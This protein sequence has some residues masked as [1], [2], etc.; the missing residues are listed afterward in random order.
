M[1]ELV[2][3]LLESFRK[4]F[5]APWAETAATVVSLY[6]GT[7]LASYE[8]V[9]W[10]YGLTLTPDQFAGSYLFKVAT[11]AFIGAALVFA[12]LQPRRG[13]EEPGRVLAAF[14]GVWVWMRGVGLRRAAAILLILAVCMGLVFR[15]LPGHARPLRVAFLGAPDFDIDAFAY[16]VYEF[17]RLQDDWHLDVDFRLLDQDVLTSAERDACPDQL[18]IVERLSSGQPT[19]AIT[20]RPLT[21]GSF[22]A[23]RGSTSVVS[24]ADMKEFSPPG[25]YEYLAFSL[26]VQ[27]VLI[28]LN[29]GC[30]GLPRGSFQSG[31]SSHAGLFE[32]TPHRQ[33]FKAGLMA[34]YLGRDE[35]ALLTRCFGVD[36]ASRVAQVLT[37]DWLHTERVTRNLAQGFHL[38]L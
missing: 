12:L 38:K 7:I 34:A 37:L 35:R 13:V 16:T 21:E 22:W 1:L 3:Q 24:T 33:A 20:S 26:I 5:P 9:H 25:V 6:L 27:A 19:I 32:A 23:N 18:C 29:E 4:R 36:Y 14:A 17:N 11:V 8:Y 28:H 2:R 15:W 31:W 30:G 10:R